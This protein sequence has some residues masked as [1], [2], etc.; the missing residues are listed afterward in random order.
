MKTGIIDVGGGLRG[1]Y[2]AGVFDYCMDEEIRFDCCIGVSAGSANAISYLAGQKRRN[3]VFYTDYVFRRKYMGFWNFLTKKSYIDMEYVYGTLSNSDGENPLNYQAMKENAAE[4]LVVAC[5]AKTGEAVYFDKTHIRQD[6]YGVLKAS[7]SIPFVCRPYEID[8]T[9]YFDGALADPVPV[10]KAFQCGCEKVVVIL[11][12]P[13]DVIRSPRKDNII[14]DRIQKKYPL[15]A[16]KLRK[17][18]EHYNQAVRLL[19]EYEAQ[20]RALIVA[21]DDTCGVDTL[22]KN[23][24]ALKRLYDKGYRDA[25]SIS[26]FLRDRER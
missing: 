4:L 7:S 11:S 6:D 19:K 20:G 15:A 12:K 13:K 1:I 5:N 10:K 14:A 23:R 21:P 3:Y 26:E 2:A 18:A 16:D 17:R 9:L 8:G 24:E 22:T 25:G